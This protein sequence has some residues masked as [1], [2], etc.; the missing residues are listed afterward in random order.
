MSRIIASVLAIL[1]SGDASFAQ[2]S[3]YQGPL[4]PGP[5]GKHVALQAG[6]SADRIAA[7]R[8]RTFSLAPSPATLPAGFG[9]SLGRIKPMIDVR[10]DQLHYGR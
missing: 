6:R 8:M 9:F 10:N 3:S 7:K 1:V 4:G 2:G 5:R